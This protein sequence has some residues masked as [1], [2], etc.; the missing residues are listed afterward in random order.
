M[1][2]NTTRQV[3]FGSEQMRYCNS[4]STTQFLLNELNNYRRIYIKTEKH[5]RSVHRF[6]PPRPWVRKW[7]HQRIFWVFPHR[8]RNHMEDA[9]RSG[10]LDKRQQFYRD[11]HHG[12][13]FHPSHGTGGENFFGTSEKRVNHWGRHY[14]R[15]RVW[16][17]YCP[18]LSLFL[19]CWLSCWEQR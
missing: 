10:Y 6:S 5:K 3:R 4:L 8:S 12:W 18:T 14:K 2:C 15:S 7:V 11:K 17:R 19:S 1:S 16:K 9:Q 13:F